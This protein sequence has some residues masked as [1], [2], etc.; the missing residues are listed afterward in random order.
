MSNPYGQQGPA[1]T[2]L[3]FAVAVL[4]IA[5]LSLVMVLPVAAPEPRMD[6]QSLDVS[7]EQSSRPARVA[8]ADMAER[9]PQDAEA[10][11]DPVSAVVP[12]V[13]GDTLPDAETTLIDAGFTELDYRDCAGGNGLKRWDSSWVVREQSP[14]AGQ[15]VMT[16]TRVT[17]CAENYGEGDASAPSPSPSSDP[18]E[19]RGLSSP[20]PSPSPSP[21]PLSGDA[22]GVDPRYDTCAEANAAGYG[23]YVQGVHSEYD[24]YDDRDNDGR[25]CERR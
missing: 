3:F 11:R 10:A 1:R 22:D 4:L 12:D 18:A 25:V 23:D 6:R 5:G 16:D 20:S 9:V 8:A 14:A 13:V 2:V 17:L 15:A 7:V 19:D 24:W 21:V